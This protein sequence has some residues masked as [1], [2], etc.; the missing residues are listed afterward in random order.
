M[1]CKQ[2]HRQTFSE[3]YVKSGSLK[4]RGFSY[5]FFY[6]EYRSNTSFKFIEIPSTTR[7]LLEN[8]R[9]LL[10]SF[11]KFPDVNTCIGVRILSDFFRCTAGND[12]SASCTALRTNI[13]N[14]ICCFDDIQI[15]LNDNDGVAAFS[16]SSAGFLSVCEHRQNED[17]LS[18]HPECK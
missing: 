16:Q 12:C 6:P 4:T 11:K 5:F 13:Y 7:L 15:V 10:I 17:R 18:A 8:R 2:A 1:F 3:H 9:F 14:I